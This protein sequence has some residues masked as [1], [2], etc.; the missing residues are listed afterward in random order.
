M[1]QIFLVRHG[2]ASFGAADYDQLSPAGVEQSRLLG[3]WLGAAGQRFGRVVTGS[4]KRH[5]QTA[6]ACVGALP[7][8][9]RPD[10]AW[11]TDA[12]FDEYDHEEVLVRHR[13]EFG[14]PIAAKDLLGKEA[15]PK[16]AFQR[17]FAE[18]MARWMGG[19]HDAEY[20]ESWAAFRARCLAALGRVVASAGAAQSAIVFTSGG[21]IA[22]ICQ[23]L[24]GVADRKAAELNF[25]LV[26]SAVTKLLYNSEGRVSLSYLNNFAHLEQ[27]GQAQVVTYR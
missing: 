3:A 12:G 5:R 1:G 23:D 13:P 26:N 8:S 6:E 17:V 7:E 25:S 24:L 4:L 9:A 10:G 2:Q 16:R 19:Q 18:A 11:H 22:A 15:N 27:T 20:R 14:D 21:P